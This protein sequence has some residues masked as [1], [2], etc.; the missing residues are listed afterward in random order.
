MWRIIMENRE[1]YAYKPDYAVHPGEYLEEILEVREIKKK[2]LSERIG[3]SVKHLSQIINK[4][5]LLTSELSVQLERTLGVSANIWNNLSSDYSLFEARKKELKDLKSKKEWIKLFPIKDLKKIGLLP[6]INDPEVLI[7][8]LLAFFG[9]PNPEQ[10]Q[11]YYTQKA[12]SFRKSDAFNENLPH[13]SA[14]LRAGEIEASK[15]EAKPFVRDVFRKNLLEIRKLTVKKPRIFESEMKRLCAESG[16]ILVFIPEFEKTHISGAVRWLTSEKALIIMSLRHKTND[17]FWFTFFHE[18]AHVL[19]HSKKDIFIDDPEGYQSKEEDEANRY[20]RN[21]L[22]PE[23]VYAEFIKE[24]IFFAEN[25][26]C[27][28]KEI[29]IHPGIVVGTLQHD[30][31]IPYSWYNKLKEKFELR[32]KTVEEEKVSHRGHGGHGGKK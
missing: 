1:Y 31:H 2:D 27:F 7:E 15:I 6:S 12:V 4:Q 29:C 21:I 9:I 32:E 10:W 26:K 19:M 5:A 28:A 25:I 18:A 8:S 23:N 30:K 20:S 13:T 22:I 24:D 3:I 11:Q 17:H 14:W 16:V